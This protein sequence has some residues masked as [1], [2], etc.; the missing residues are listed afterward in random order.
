[1]TVARMVTRIGRYELWCLG[2]RRLSSRGLKVP[3]MRIGASRRSV[4]ILAAAPFPQPQRTADPRSAGRIERS[5]E[6][7]RAWFKGPEADLLYAEH[8]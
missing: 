5:D 6:S 1:M 3:H 7:D 4:S 8:G 2:S